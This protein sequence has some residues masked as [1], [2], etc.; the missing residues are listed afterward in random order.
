MATPA[1]LAANRQNAQLSTGPRTE[2]GKAAVAGNHTTHGLAGRHVVLPGEDPDEYDRLLAELLDEHKPAGPT[3]RFLVQQ[4]AQAQWKLD[5][6]ARMEQQIFERRMASGEAADPAA[7]WDQ[8]CAGPNSLLKLGRYQAA[9]QRAWFKA[10]AALQSLQ[11]PRHAEDAGG[12][13]DQ[14]LCEF[15]QHIIER[16]VGGSPASPPPKMQN[17]SSKP[18]SPARRAAYDAAGALHDRKLAL[19][20]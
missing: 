2:E 17:Y 10:L 20:L 11:S 7:A 19:R 4:M 1:Q 13:A 9:A 18:I 6:I 15:I 3:E 5:R 14:R 16:P 12:I 8:D